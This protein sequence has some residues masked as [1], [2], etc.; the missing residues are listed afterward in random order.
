[1]DV[2][3]VSTDFLAAGVLFRPRRRTA[4]GEGRV[5]DRSRQD[6]RLGEE[7]PDADGRAVVLPDHVV[8]GREH[9]EEGR[10]WARPGGQVVALLTDVC[11]LVELAQ[12]RLAGGVANARNRDGERRV[13]AARV[14]EP[15]RV[16]LQSRE[17]GG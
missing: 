17:A 14:P 7:R 13:A 15:A 5:G 6:E 2:L 9:V 8:L 4:A 11:A 1:M 16:L 3:E 12:D 10:E